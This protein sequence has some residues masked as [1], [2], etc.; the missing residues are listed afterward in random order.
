M[1]IYICKNYVYIYKYKSIHMYTYLKL[2]IYIIYIAVF[3]LAVKTCY[4]CI[5]IDNLF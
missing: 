3:S 1:Y 2:N 4:I 5:Y